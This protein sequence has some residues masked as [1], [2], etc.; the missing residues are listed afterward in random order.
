MADSKDLQDLLDFYLY[1]D[2]YDRESLEQYLKK[3]DIDI[4]V[5]AENLTGFMQ[6][7]QAELKLAEGRKLR[8]SY[9]DA[10]NSEILKETDGENYTTVESEMISAFRKAN[11]DA[12]EDDKDIADDMKK[13]ALLKKLTEKKKTPNR[14]E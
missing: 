9:L 4:E 10:V 7:K 13:I 6:Q 2:L 11:S 8:E 1:S 5:M 14:N 3:A 12:D